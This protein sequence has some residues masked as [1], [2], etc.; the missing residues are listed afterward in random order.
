MEPAPFAAK[1]LGGPRRAQNAR[2]G[3][4]HSLSR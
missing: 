2:L 3:A 4:A 1:P